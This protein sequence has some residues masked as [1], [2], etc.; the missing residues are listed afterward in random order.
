[1]HVQYFYAT[2][3]LSRAVDACQGISRKEKL[4]GRVFGLYRAFYVSRTADL[5]RNQAADTIIVPHQQVANILG[6][7]LSSLDK[8]YF[9]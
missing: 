8:F 7:T 9:N 3:T 4:A 6:G 2:R 1:M 5:V